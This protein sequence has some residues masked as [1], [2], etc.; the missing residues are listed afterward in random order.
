MEKKVNKTSNEMKYTLPCKQEEKKV[1]I[2]QKRNQVT[3]QSHT[4]PATSAPLVVKY[5]MLRYNT[6]LFCLP[7][8]E[9]GAD[10]HFTYGNS[11]TM[12]SFINF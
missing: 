1:R 4:R 2:T 10:Y 6:H 3:S 7:I 5:Y 12:E 9:A 8:A 11:R